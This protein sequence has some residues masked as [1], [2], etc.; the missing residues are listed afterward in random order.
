MRSLRTTKDWVEVMPI[1]QRVLRLPMVMRAVLLAVYAELREEQCI[2][3]VGADFF[4]ISRRAGT[5]VEYGTIHVQM[6][7]T[8]RIAF[9]DTTAAECIDCSVS[10]PELLAKAVAWIRG[11]HRG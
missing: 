2:T 10:D 6:D 9:I 11:K 8:E 5:R 1:E 3:Y 4:N 7:G